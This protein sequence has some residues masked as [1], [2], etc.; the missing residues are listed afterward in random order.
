MYTRVA[1]AGPPPVM[2]KA[3]SKTWKLP[4][5]PRI[6]VSRMVGVIIGTVTWRVFC[7]RPAPSMTAAS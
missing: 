7:H 2:M 3:L 1:F 5:T 6:A 4:I